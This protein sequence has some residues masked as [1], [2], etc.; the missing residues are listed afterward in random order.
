MA[1]IAFAA[2]I[3]IIQANYPI[4]PPEQFIAQMRTD[5]TGAAGYQDSFWFNF[6][7]IKLSGQ[8]L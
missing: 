3:K 8:S 1:D 7:H 6:R 5:E 4:A 2:G